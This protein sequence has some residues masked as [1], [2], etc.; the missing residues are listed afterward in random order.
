MKRRNL[1]AHP[2]ARINSRHLFAVILL[3]LLTLACG[4]SSTAT[5]SNPQATIDAAVAATGNAQAAVQATI[6]AAVQATAEAGSTEAGAPVVISQTITVVEPTPAATTAPETSDEYVTMTEEE[7]VAAIDQAVAEAVAATEEST[8]AT[9][10]ATADATLTEEEVQTVEV[11]VSG[12]E[13]AVAAAEELIMLYYDLYGEQAAETLATVEEISDSLEEIAA[14]TAAMAAS[15]EEIDNTLA[16]GLELAEETIAELEA[17]AQAAGSQAEQVQQQV[18]TW[19][20]D[21]PA[22]VEERVASAL[23][24]QPNQVA[25]DPQGAVQSAFEFVSA[26][27]AAL[28]DGRVSAEELATLAQLG[29][30][31]SASL[32]AQGNPQ[33]QQVSGMITATTEQMA[34]GNVSQASEMLSQLGLSTAQSVQP[35]QVATDLQGA[36]GIALE[37][38]TTGQQALADGTVS[39]AELATLTQLAANTSASLNAQGIPQ[40]QQLSGSASQ[41]TEQLAMGNVSQA[42]MGLNDF[43]NSLATLPEVSSPSIADRPAAPDKPAMP[44]SPASPGKSARPSRP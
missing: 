11:Y 22:Q 5:T 2:A 31:A 41:I 26:G 16:A 32:N 39:G 24:T 7:L 17:A 25:T 44:D 13:E 6:D 8:T 4:L 1:K 29:A 34:R 9:A 15:L 20:V 42:Q 38:A 35:S 12:A 18:Q 43:G 30:N 10:D 33:L 23:T 3:I 40:L 28:G 19:M 36:I 14:Y 21:Y 27:Q 37:F